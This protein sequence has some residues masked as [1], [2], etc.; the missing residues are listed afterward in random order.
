MN[1]LFVFMNSLFIFMNSMFILTN[2]VGTMFRCFDVSSY[3]FSPNKLRVDVSICRYDILRF[4][5]GK[6]SN[7]Y[8]GTIIDIVILYAW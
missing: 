1:S 4:Q 7:V 3:V 8:N 5:G 6:G 2:A